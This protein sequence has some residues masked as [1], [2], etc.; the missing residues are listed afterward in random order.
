EDEAAES[1][2]AVRRADTRLAAADRGG[3]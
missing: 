3:R 1:E 2:A